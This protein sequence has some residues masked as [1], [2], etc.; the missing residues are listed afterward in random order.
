[1]CGIS[2]FTFKDEALIKRMN[3]LISHRGPDETNFWCGETVSLGHNRLAIIDLSPR[4]SQPMW[5]S[6]RETA[7]VFNGEIYNYLELRE[8]LSKKYAFRSVSDTEVILYAYKEYGADCVNKL[9]GIFALAIWDARRQELFL[10]RDHLGV[11]PL[12]YHQDGGRL[13]FSSEIKALLEH[14]LPRAVDRDA[15]NF[16]TS[17]LYVPE[18]LTMFAGIKK[19]PAGH[20]AVFNGGRLTVQRYWQVENFAD[21][22][23]RR[24]AT[25][26]VRDLFK[27]AVRRQLVSDRPVGVFLSGGI[28][29]TAVLGAVKERSHGPVKTFSVGFADSD[30]DKFNSDFNLARQTARH[31]GTDHHELT[32]SARDIGDNLERIAW[33]LDEPNF[34][35]TAGAIFLLA[36]EAKKNVA[37]VLGGDGG[38]ELFGGYPRYLYSRWLSYYQTAPSWLRRAGEI[39]ARLAAPRLGER[40]AKLELPPNE[41]RVLAFLALKDDL[42]REVLSIGP[43]NNGLAAEYLR[44]RYFSRQPPTADF[45]KY[46]MHI[47]QEGW[48]VDESLLRIDKMTMAFG[49][50]E[51]VPILDRRLAEL[52]FRLPTRWKLGVWQKPDDFQGKRIWR[53]AVAGYL[54]PHVLNQ[55]KRGW[56]TPMAKWIR[57]DLR[58]QVA[59]II[60]PA[61]LNGEFFNADGVQRVW[62]D[63]LS[64]RRYN[65]NIIWA[66][67]MWQLW[68]RQFIKK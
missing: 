23:D 39:M 2:G 4:A 56:F 43:I 34:N 57:G 18:P 47:D 26:L 55:K 52:A 28:D 1:M 27:D 9:N 68:Y 61:N 44:N 58:D 63:H 14:D 24:A 17:L 60:A 10:A 20:Y 22:T 59:E 13:I 21:L 33:H 40:L 51:R 36:Q 54:P 7:I 66:I 41:L 15:F 35:A 64:G 8:S 32:V 50:E 49:L 11:K 19:L 6:A 65:L 12:Y 38:D 48:L 25:D 67:T 5:D 3:D 31:Y 37:V 42:R 62:Q 29:S 16:Y 45:E 46:F 30:D 53:A